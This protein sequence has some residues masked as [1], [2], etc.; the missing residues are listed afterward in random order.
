LYAT[1]HITHTSSKTHVGHTADREKSDKTFAVTAFDG[2][3]SRQL[4]DFENFDES[5]TN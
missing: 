3:D 1:V 4:C 2:S 5:C